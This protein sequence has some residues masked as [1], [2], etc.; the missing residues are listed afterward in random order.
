VR[1][2][3]IYISD[4]LWRQVKVDAASRGVTSSQV[5]TA[6][7]EQHFV[8]AGKVLPVTMTAT[9][10]KVD[11]DTRPDELADQLE[12]TFHRP[13]TPVPKPTGRKKR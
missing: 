2:R 11:P 7:L 4:D 5:V 9:P 13:F 1:Q 10:V 6:A 8:P 3:S 12:Q